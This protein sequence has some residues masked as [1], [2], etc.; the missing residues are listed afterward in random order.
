MPLSND[1]LIKRDCSNVLRTSITLPEK[2]TKPYPEPPA[3]SPMSCGVSRPTCKDLVFE[4]LAVA[5]SFGKLYFIDAAFRFARPDMHR[6]STVTL[7]GNILTLVLRVAA[8]S[9]AFAAFPA[10]GAFPHRKIRSA[11]PSILLLFDHFV[12]STL[13]LGLWFASS[14]VNLA[15]IQ[16]C[17]CGTCAHPCSDT[18]YNL[19]C[20][21]RKTQ[22][23][24][25]VETNMRKYRP[26]SCQM[27]WLLRQ[28]RE[29]A[30]TRVLMERAWEGVGNQHVRHVVD[31]RNWRQK[32]LKANKVNPWRGVSGENKPKSL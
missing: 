9:A 24:E 28:E 30:G 2:R 29:W 14:L 20:L 12:K 17:P 1:P 6:H 15:V 21:M 23:D 3:L 11:L 7:I 13:S 22:F 16:T 18:S 26:H 19:L 10:A 31:D 32:Y 27:H 8:A 5:S 25:F 4:T